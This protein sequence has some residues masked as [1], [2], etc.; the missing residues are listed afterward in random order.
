MIGPEPSAASF[1]HLLTV[2][3]K[4]NGNKTVRDYSVRSQSGEQVAS[5]K[6]EC[7]DAGKL[8]IRRI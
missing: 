7:G 5:L 6:G 2:I 8:T 1:F 4:F 3:V